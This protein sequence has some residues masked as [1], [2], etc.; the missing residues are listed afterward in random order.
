MKNKRADNVAIKNYGYNTHKYIDLS[1]FCGH[2]TYILTK[3]RVDE[4][5][6]VN[7]TPHA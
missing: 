3:W 4:Q 7:K 5:C 1:I 2:Y 6:R